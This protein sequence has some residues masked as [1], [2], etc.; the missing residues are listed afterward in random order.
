MRFVARPRRPLVQSSFDTMPFRWRLPVLAS[1]F[2][3]TLGQAVDLTETLEGN[4]N[5]TEFTT[6]LREQYGEVYANLSFAREM[7]LLVPSNAAFN[8]IPYSTLGDAF[9]NNESDIVRSVLQYHVSPGLHPITSFNSS[10]QFV[11]TWLTNSSFTNVTGGQRVGVVNQAGNVTVLTSGLGS[12]ATVVENVRSE[13]HDSFSAFTL[14]FPG[15]QILQR[16]QQRDHSR[17]RFLPRSSPEL[18]PD[19][20]AIQPDCIW[21]CGDQ[22]QEGRLREHSE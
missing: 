11:P 12:R 21:W 18:H 8:K 7:T 22:S 9:K 13:H 6:L 4:K 3:A 10:F 20:P 5:L 17:H 19:V 14:T 1:L 16:R 2:L 15:Y